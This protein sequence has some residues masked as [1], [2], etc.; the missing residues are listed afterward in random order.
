MDKIKSPLT[1]IMEIM[2]I[3]IKRI[4]TGGQKDSHDKHIVTQLLEKG[5]SMDDIDMAMGIVAMITSKVDPIVT[6]NNREKSSDGKFSG[7]RQLNAKEAV[8]LT[9]EAQRYLLSG[10]EDGS[11]TSLQYE[12]TLLYL[13]QM[14]LRGVNKTKLE[15]ILTMNK[16]VDSTESK[17]FESCDDYYYSTIH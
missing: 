13:Q 17:G 5:F 15:I 10:L 4:E 11:I 7:V 16:P 6:V 9:P 3:V 14:D 8:R 1:N 2:N 12:R